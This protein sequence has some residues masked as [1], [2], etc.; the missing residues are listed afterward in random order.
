MTFHQ[1]YTT[2]TMVLE[3]KQ[4]RENIPLLFVQGIFAADAG[5]EV[6]AS[7][8]RPDWNGSG[9]YLET[10]EFRC[11]E[12]DNQ[13]QIRLQIPA[14]T[15]PEKIG[16]MIR[17]GSGRWREEDS[18]VLGRYAVAQL[19]PGDDAIALVQ[20]RSVPWLLIGLAA[21][22]VAGAGLYIRKKKT[23]A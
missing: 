15:D 8:I 23:K 7:D 6:A 18:H 2:Q 3:S 17:D 4:I 13:E 10:W 16:V 21:V 11:T 19:M 12:P 20:Y 9:K 1:E 5:L 22:F 14:N